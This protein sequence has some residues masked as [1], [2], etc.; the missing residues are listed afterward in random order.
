MPGLVV[1]RGTFFRRCV[2]AI[3]WITY[4]AARR[5]AKGVDSF[6]SASFQKSLDRIL[7]Q[8]IGRRGVSFS[9]AIA[10]RAGCCA[11]AGAFRGIATGSSVMMLYF[12]N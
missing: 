5:D 1:A 12:G 7:P 9:D 2:H 8:R 10:S 4:R 3:Q 6:K 11:P